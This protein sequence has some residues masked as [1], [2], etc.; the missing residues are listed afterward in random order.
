MSGGGGGNQ[1][2]TN[3]ENP[4]SKAAHFLYNEDEFYDSAGN[5]QGYGT[6]VYNKV[7]D[8]W[9]PHVYGR[10]DVESQQGNDPF[11]VFYY[12]PNQESWLPSNRVAD[13]SPDQLAAMDMTR[14]LALDSSTMDPMQNVMMQ[15]LGNQGEGRTEINDTWNQLVRPTMEGFYLNPESNTYLQKYV[16]AAQQPLIENYQ[17]NILPS[18]NQGAVGAGRY[19]SNAWQTGVTQAGE[20]LNRQLGNVAANIYAPAYE[21]ERN[22]QMESSGYAPAMYEMF[23]GQ[24]G[25]AQ[26]NLMNL[27][28]QQFKNAGY[29]AST[30]EAQQGQTQNDINANMQ[31]WQDMIYGPMDYTNSLANL[32]MSGGGLGRTSSTSSPYSGP[33]LGQSLLGTGSS[34]AGIANQLMPLF[35]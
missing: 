6:G 13:F 23:A 11:G 19:G 8:V 18:L 27:L 21:S 16:D 20:D 5:P 35:S 2:V 3:V 12:G 26:N 14:S 29:L 22:R 24:Q 9:N 28:N 31:L 15:L 32:F 10:M 7:Q 25:N 30:G 4:W 17:Q 33:T 34:L 1:T